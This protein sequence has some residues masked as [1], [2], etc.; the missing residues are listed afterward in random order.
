MSCIIWFLPS[1][2]LPLQ[3]RLTD[4][5]DLIIIRSL[6]CDTKVIEALLCDTEPCSREGLV[7]GSDAAK[8]EVHLCGN[9]FACILQMQVVQGT[10]SLWLLLGSYGGAGDGHGIKGL[11]QAPDPSGRSKDSEVD[12]HAG[13]PC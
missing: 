13:W 2:P 12:V 11:F 3:L 9:G 4:S 7:N 5:A 6:R 1:A 8:V 10:A